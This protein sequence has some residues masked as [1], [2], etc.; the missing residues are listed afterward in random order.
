MRYVFFV[1]TVLFVSCFQVTA[2]S[3]FPSQVQVSEAGL[4]WAGNSINAVVFRK[5]SIASFGDIQC[6]SYYDNDG[7]VVLGKRNVHDTGWQIK[8]TNLTGNVQDAHNSI[9]IIFDG[10]GYLH[11]AWDHHNGPLKYTRSVAPLSLELAAPV[12]MI[13]T[14]EQ[15]VS[16]PEFYKMPDGNLLFLYRDGGSGNGNLVINKYE[17][18]TQK[19]SR[20]QHNLI[21]GEGQRNAYWQACTD[22][23]GTIHI[24]WVWRESPE[25]SS[26]HDLCYARS[27]DGGITWQKS[28]GEKYQLPITQS[29]AELVV[30]IPQKSN[31][32]NQTSMCADDAGRPFIASYWNDSNQIPQYQVAYKK[33]KSWVVQAAGFRKTGFVLGGVGTKKIPVSRPQ[34]ICSGKG[35]NTAVYLLFRDEEREIKY[36]WPVPKGW[37]TTNGNCLICTI[38]IPDHGSPVLI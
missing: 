1:W 3:Y 24:S 31:L 16:Y 32:I 14:D 11:M 19:W 36:R 26:N 18:A 33:G 15:K 6:I 35:K 25:V 13:S 12:A 10:D 4:G 5:Q 23:K 27:T 7:Y 22:A 8:R 38:K 30:G 34:I 21:D 28:T 37:T 9:S 17:T 29:N 20:L 2:Q